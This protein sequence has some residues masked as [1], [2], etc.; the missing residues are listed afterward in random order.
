MHFVGITYSVI[1]LLI[2]QLRMPPA[3]IKTKNIHPDSERLAIGLYN[4]P[5]LHPF[6]RRVPNPMQ[7][8]PNANTAASFFLMRSPDLNACT[9]CPAVSKYMKA[10]TRMPKFCTEAP[11]RKK[12][13]VNVSADI[14][15][16]L[17]I[18]SGDMPNSINSLPTH[19]PKG[20]D[21]P[22]TGFSD[23]HQEHEKQSKPNSTLP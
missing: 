20:V 17:A 14:C 10:P 23:T 16:K 8:P 11:C 2:L 1:L 6:A 7:M 9:N 12:G 21:A 15:V 19:I 5:T 3:T 22:P 4:A 18:D 13:S